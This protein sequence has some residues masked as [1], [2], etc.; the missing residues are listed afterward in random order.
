MTSTRCNDYTFKSRDQRPFGIEPS[1]HK[2]EFQSITIM[3]TEIFV[4]TIVILLEF[5]WMYLLLSTDVVLRAQYYLTTKQ[6]LR[7]QNIQNWNAP[8]KVLKVVKERM[9]VLQPPIFYELRFLQ[10]PL[11]TNSPKS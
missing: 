1:F 10:I 7:H 6:C 4:A 11:S 2:T 9:V 3:L 5:T 8:E